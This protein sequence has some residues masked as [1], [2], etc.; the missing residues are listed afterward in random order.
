MYGLRVSTHRQESLNPDT[1]G[2]PMSPDLLAAIEASLLTAPPELSLGPAA[3]APP[4]GL[5]DTR[6]GQWAVGSASILQATATSSPNRQQQNSAVHR[7]QHRPPSAQ[8]SVYQPLDERSS[9][10]RNQ[11]PPLPSSSTSSSQMQRCPSSPASLSSSTS[12]SLWES[13]TAVFSTDPTSPALSSMAADSADSPVPLSLIGSPDTVADLAAATGMTVQEILLAQQTALLQEA[14][15]SAGKQQSSRS[16]SASAS[17]PSSGRARFPASAAAGAQE[18]FPAL[19]SPGSST[20]FGPL[21]PGRSPH[22]VPAGWRGGRSNI[23]GQ[24]VK[25]INKGTAGDDSTTLKPGRLDLHW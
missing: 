6:Q 13:F 23:R 2:S 21:Q 1:V 19:S 17:R 11:F 8:R 25:V 9:D 15:K 14:N 5:S 12:G 4:D 16:R 24:G 22:A 3:I 20:G 10:H 7:Q 18:D